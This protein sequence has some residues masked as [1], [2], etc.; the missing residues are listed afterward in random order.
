MTPKVRLSILSGL[1]RRYHVRHGNSLNPSP[2]LAVPAHLTITGRIRAVQPLQENSKR[3]RTQEN[4]DRFP[5]DGH[6]SMTIERRVGQSSQMSFGG[7]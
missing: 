3:P 1:K 7:R 6:L 4:M 2:V 5:N